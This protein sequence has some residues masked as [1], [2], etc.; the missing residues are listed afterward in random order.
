MSRLW[1]LLVVAIGAVSA[2]GWWWLSPRN[3]PVVLPQVAGLELAHHGLPETP[4]T[5]TLK[6]R[7][8]MVVPGSAGRLRIG[9]DDV[10]GGQVKVD[11]LADDQSMISAKSLRPGDLATFLFDGQ[12]LAIRL[13]SL[14]NAMIGDDFATLVV[15]EVVAPV[16]A[17]STGNA[18][19]SQ[20]LAETSAETE[21]EA[22][23]AAIAARKGA[24]FIRN[25]EEHD[26]QEALAHLRMKWEHAD[27][28]ITSAEQFIDQIATRS[29]FSG[30]AYVIRF[31]DSATVEVGPWLHQRLT[32]M[33]LHPKA[34]LQRDE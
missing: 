9:I 5:V 4:V 25:G 26:A 24:I 1:V 21:I 33:R 23:L 6:Q 28:R 16:A 3:A 32:E 7:S 13:E 2:A 18:T 31:A 17:D 8:V 14:S 30:Q 22:L 12:S 20:D 27:P 29:S 11:V 10:T 15:D 19:A 34:A